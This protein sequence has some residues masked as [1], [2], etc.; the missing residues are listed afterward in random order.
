MSIVVTPHRTRLTRRANQAHIDIIARIIRPAPE[1][2]SGR[3][4]YF[5]TSCKIGFDLPNPVC[6]IF[7]KVEHIGR[8][9]G[10]GYSSS[11][12]SKGRQRH[13]RCRPFYQ[14]RYNLFV[15]RM[16]SAPTLRV[17]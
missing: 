1:D 11:Q 3:F 10:D 17:G 15:F 13:N 8:I 6:S 14:A 5:G 12:I 16:I 7:D 4:R 9:T 2:R